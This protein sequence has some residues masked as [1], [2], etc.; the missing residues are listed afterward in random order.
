[1]L[2]ALRP[3]HFRFSRGRRIATFL[4]ESAVTSTLDLIPLGGSPA[5]LIPVL[6]LFYE[7]IG[8]ASGEI[9][10]T[11]NIDVIEHR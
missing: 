11:G 9:R 1:M 3:I 8:G 6:P 2:S 4:A 7:T 10:T 5:P